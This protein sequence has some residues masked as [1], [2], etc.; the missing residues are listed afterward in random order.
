[1]KIS[2]NNSKLSL[3][4]AFFWYS[5]LWD[6]IEITPFLKNLNKQNAEITYLTNDDLWKHQLINIPYI[7]KLVL[8]RNNFCD[9]L[10]FYLKILF[11]NFDYVIFE[12]AYIRTP[13]RYFYLLIALTFFSKHI[14]YFSWKLDKR[15][16]KFIDQLIDSKN[17]DLWVVYKEIFEYIYWNNV[18]YNNEIEIFIKWEDEIP[19]INQFLKNNKKNNKII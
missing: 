16:S 17:K 5:H 2:K 15:K 12:H 10:S 6:C 8:M 19:Y 1:M 14:A 9:K 3:K 11:G 4:I 13:L 18:K 7:K